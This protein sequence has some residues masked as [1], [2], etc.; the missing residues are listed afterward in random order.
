[1]K[2]ERTL[3][4]QLATKI[5]VSDLEDISAAGGVTQQWTANGTYNSSGWDG[6]LDATWDC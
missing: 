1:M 5:N 4:Y 2:N 6:T 3:A